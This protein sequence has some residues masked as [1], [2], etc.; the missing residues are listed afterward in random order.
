MCLGFAFL[1][2]KVSLGIPLANIQGA[3]SSDQWSP[4]VSESHGGGKR[5]RWLLLTVT[6]NLRGSGIQRYSSGIG[7]KESVLFDDLFLNFWF[8][9]FLHEVIT[10]HQLRAIDWCREGLVLVEFT[11]RFLKQMNKH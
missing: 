4:T 2:S 6:L 3:W 1:I 10:E 9:L 5:G 11:L 7:Q 8:H